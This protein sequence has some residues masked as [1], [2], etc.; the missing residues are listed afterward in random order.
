MDHINNIVATKLRKQG[1]HPYL[2]PVGGTSPLGAWSYF[3]AVEELAYQT[4]AATAAGGDDD[5]GFDHIVFAA[6]S[7]GTATGIG[8]G[9]HL[10]QL[11]GSPRV[12]AVNVQH[13]PETYFT[14]IQEEAEALGEQGDPRDWLSIHH[15]E[16]AGYGR[17]TDVELRFIADIAATSG[18]ILDHTYTGKAL[19]HFCE[20]ARA[21]L[22]EFRG[23]R[24][25]FW[26][27][28]DHLYFVYW[29]LN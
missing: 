6:G 22:D 18:V 27:A 15:G 12:H 16:G 7:G 28:F 24:I 14:S 19:Y 8:L 25:L 11:P 29:L 23:K 17:S 13:T 2:V 26:C 3:S 1:R 21:T 5:C 4:A 9:C 10:A 20:Y